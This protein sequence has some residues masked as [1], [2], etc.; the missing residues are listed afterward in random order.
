M[1][2]PNGEAILTSVNPALLGL[3]PQPHPSLVS[4]APSEAAGPSKPKLKP[5]PKQTERVLGQTLL[6]LARV[7]KIMKADKELAGTGKD[8]VFLISVA[9][10]FPFP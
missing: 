10:V 5:R 6:P 2:N 9:T 7:Q 4:E 1:H 8:A 3:P